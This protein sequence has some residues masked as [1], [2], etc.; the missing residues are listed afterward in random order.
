M[1]IYS[2]VT[3]WEIPKTEDPGGLQSVV[4]QSLIQLSTYTY[5]QIYVCVYIWCKL[6]P[7]AL[8]NEF[9]VN[10]SQ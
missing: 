10:H 5:T 8:T 3:T 1:A 9:S 7:Q 6:I 2:S 4:S